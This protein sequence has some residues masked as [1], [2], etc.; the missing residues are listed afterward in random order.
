MTLKQFLRELKGLKAQGF[1]ACLLHDGIR[2]AKG[3]GGPFCF[4][5]IT[6]VCF[7]MTKECFAAVGYNRA[8]DLLG[9]NTDSARKIAA[10]ADFYSSSCHHSHSPK[11]RAKMLK[12]LGL[13]EAA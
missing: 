13:E 2:L 5:P 4:C 10:S 6:A 1:R 3:R 12:A 7:A 8:I 11:L 9:I